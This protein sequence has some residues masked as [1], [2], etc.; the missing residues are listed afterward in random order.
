MSFEK[1]KIG[2]GGIADEWN[3]VIISQQGDCERES[4]QSPCFRFYKVLISP[5][6]YQKGL[7]RIGRSVPVHYI[8]GIDPVWVQSYIGCEKRACR[9][10][11]A[12]DA[13]GI[14]AA[15]Y[16]TE[17]RGLTEADR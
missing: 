3:E 13:D 7:Y 5:I 8:K 11:R 12:G 15:S 17:V 6:L 2:R 10:C 9:T 1:E 4:S 16:D 14:R